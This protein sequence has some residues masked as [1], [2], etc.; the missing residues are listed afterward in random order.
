MHDSTDVGMLSRYLQDDHI[1]LGGSDKTYPLIS[2]RSEQT[3]ASTHASGY[4]D[5]KEERSL[6]TRKAKSC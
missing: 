5:Q 3:V 2:D 1:G 4:S 6:E